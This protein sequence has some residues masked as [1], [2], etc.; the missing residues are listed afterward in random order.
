MGT[1]GHLVAFKL[2]DLMD[3]DPSVVT[4]EDSG[5]LISETGVHGL[6]YRAT[7]ELLLAWPAPATSNL[8]ARPLHRNLARAR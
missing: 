8:K 5:S 3:R 7:K 1:C 2:C 4:I 6:T